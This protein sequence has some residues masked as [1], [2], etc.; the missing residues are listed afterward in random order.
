MKLRGYLAWRTARIRDDVRYLRQSNGCGKV[1]EDFSFSFSCIL[2]N[3]MNFYG[4]SELL[5]VL[6]LKL[7]YVKKIDNYSLASINLVR[8]NWSNVTKK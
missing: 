3:T 2:G 1:W 6:K 4:A 7:S 8:E 5:G